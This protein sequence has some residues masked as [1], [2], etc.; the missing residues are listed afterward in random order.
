MR[1][2]HTFR[3]TSHNRYRPPVAKV[4]GTVRGVPFEQVFKTMPAAER[5]AAEFNGFVV[6]L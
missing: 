4:I 5:A 1:S 2:I 6:K 3:P